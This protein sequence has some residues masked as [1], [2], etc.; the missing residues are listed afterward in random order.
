MSARPAALATLSQLPAGV[1]SW[2]DAVSEPVL[3]LEDGPAGLRLVHANEA[4]CQAVSLDRDALLSRGLAAWLGPEVRERLAHATRSAL[5]SGRARCRELDPSGAMIELRRLE[6]G[7]AEYC[8][9]T[10]R[11]AAGTSAAPLSSDELRRRAD[12]LTTAMDLEGM[13]AW[14]W[15]LHSDELCLEYRAAA[16][17]FVPLKEPVLRSF[18]EQVFADDRERVNGVVREALRDD[19]IH[20]VE[21]RFSTPGRQ[22]RWISSALKRFVDKEGRAAGLV[23]A[24]R[25][26]TRR[27]DVYQELAENE[28]RLRTVLDNEPECVKIVDRHFA[29]TM[30]NAAGRAMIGAT[31]ETPVIGGDARELVAPEHRAAFEAFHERV[32]AGST[33]ILEFEIV[34]LGGERRWVESHAAPLR[35]AAGGIVGQLAVTRDVTESRRLA[36]SLIEAADVEQERIGRD[37]HDGL[38]QDLTGISLMLRSL[39]GQLDRPPEVLQ[40]ELEEVIDLVSRMMQG[41]RMLARGLSPVAVEQGGLGQALRQLVERARES[42]RLRVRLTLRSAGIE[43]LEPSCAIQ[44]YRIAQEAFSNAQRHAQATRLDVSLTDTRS[45][46]RLRIADDGRGLPPHPAPGAGLGLRSMDYRARLIGATLEVIRRA[47]GGTAVVVTLPAARAGATTT[48][49]DGDTGVAPRRVLLVDDHPIVRQ[50]LRRLIGN[51]P[52]LVVCAEAET[53]REA[54]QA[55]RDHAPDIVVADLS[56][57]D[58]DGMDLVKDIRAHHPGLPVLV[59]SMHDESVFAERLLAAGASGYIMKHAASEQFILALRRLLDGGMY[60]SEAVATQAGGAAP[61]R[62]GRGRTGSRFPGCPTASCRSC[63]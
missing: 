42:G 41:T 26:V 24:S 31:N 44:L 36:Q 38:G 43:D 22:L 34:G 56:L 46:L 29:L 11:L 18:F 47:A 27:K 8:I 17:E 23:G 61:G 39:Q 6:A 25:D 63:R 19:R 4:L 51:E 28:Q 7:D 30:M 52:G 20:Q 12:L 53:V 15:N 21:F 16:A 48:M 57:R 5:L 55:I 54:R 59:L 49:T 1:I 32:L 37:L 9:G 50:G 45:G 13:V 62:G 58:G 33:E 2:L 14:S 3:V 40:A 10:L 35:D 60:V